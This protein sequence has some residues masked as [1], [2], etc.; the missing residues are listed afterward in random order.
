MKITTK[1][2]TFFSILT[3]VA[4]GLLMTAITASIPA[5][6]AETAVSLPAGTS[7]PGCEET[8]A[9][10]TPSSVNVGVGE[11]VTWSNDDTAAHTVTSG[12]AS[13]GP[14]GVFDSS[15]FAAGTTFSHTFEEEGAFDYFCMVHP[16][17]VGAVTVGTAM[18][19]ES[20]SSSGAVESEPEATETETATTETMT[21]S[22][23][24]DVDYDVTGGG[25][26]VSVTPD[27]ET[28]S[29]IVELE[30]T[31]EQG[32]LTITLPRDV[33][34][35]KT[36]NDEDDDFFAL[37]D[38]EEVVFEET[39]TDADRTLAIEFPA[40]AEEVEIIGT[41]VVP[42]FGTIAMM[43]LAIAIIS[44]VAVSAKSRLSIIPRL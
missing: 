24:F 41:F 2:K 40:G 33:M 11:T 14:D 9:C 8:D 34:D 6:Y 3:I 27:S 38:G 29:V 31:T 5:A 21:E 4:A 25:N 20:S 13:G 43:I 39:K 23:E 36:S 10:Y 16:W 30:A 37:V 19:A 1:T 22:V 44:I 18:A 17:M 28:S 15:L 7:V 32:V 26:V 12:T 42:E 35:A